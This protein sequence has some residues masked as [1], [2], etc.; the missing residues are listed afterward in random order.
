MLKRLEQ[1]LE[2]SI[3]GKVAQ[4]ERRLEKE[5]KRRIKL[6]ADHEWCEKNRARL[7]ALLTVPSL[8]QLFKNSK[9]PDVEPAPRKRRPRS[10]EQ[11]D[12]SSDSSDEESSSSDD[13]N[14][15]DRKSRRR[16]RK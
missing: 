9:F 8:L 1:R 12:S 2:D 4:L 7:D 5:R 10:A 6:E 15:R 3:D 16:S 14:H 11:D 13:S